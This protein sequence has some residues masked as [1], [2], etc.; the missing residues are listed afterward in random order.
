MAC[1]GQGQP[2]RALAPSLRRQRLVRG[3]SGRLRRAAAIGLIYVR[4]AGA[5]DDGPAVRIMDTVR[6]AAAD[7]EGD[8]HTCRAVYGIQ[9]GRARENGRGLSQLWYGG[10][11]ARVPAQR[12]GGEVLSFRLPLARTREDTVQVRATVGRQAIGRRRTPFQVGDSRG[13]RSQQAVG[14]GR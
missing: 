7:G 10:Q 2:S 4:V 12:E 6:C 1:Y 9:T 8:R 5:A 11:Q 3:E 13:R 14:R